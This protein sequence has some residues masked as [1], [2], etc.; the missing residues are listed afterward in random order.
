MRC[1]RWVLSGLL[2]VSENSLSD[3]LLDLKDCLIIEPY[4][5]LV[6]KIIDV[7]NNY[8]VYCQQYKNQLEKN[9]V[10]IINQRSHQLQLF[11]KLLS[12][13]SSFTKL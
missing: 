8:D 9:K 6:D 13:K 5:N 12:E 3:E 11:Q 1:D 4:D 7:I 10:N 2:V